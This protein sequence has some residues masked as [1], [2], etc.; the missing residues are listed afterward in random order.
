MNTEHEHPVVTIV[1]DKA[2]TT[3]LEVARHFQ[4]QHGHVIRDIQNLAIPD[5][6]RLS[7]FGESNYVNEQGKTQPMYE[8]TRDGFSLLVMGF[9]GAE[10]MR[11]KLAYIAAFNAMEEALRRIREE[12]IAAAAKRDALGYFR[13]G[14]A[15]TALLRKRDILEKVEKFYW[16]RVHG[17]LTHYEAAYCCALEPPEADDIARSLRDVGLALPV[18]QNAARKAEISRYFSEA[19]GGFLPEEIRGALAEVRREVTR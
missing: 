8:L 9:T 5:E 12:A 15:L 3:S 6:F 2:V 11:F 13:K 7:N 4:K 16:L 1:N 10:A 18:I 14:A 17:Q 19:V